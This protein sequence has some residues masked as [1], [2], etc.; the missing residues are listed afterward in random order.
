MGM[1]LK[2]ATTYRAAYLRSGIYVRGDAQC[3]HGCLSEDSFGKLGSG[4]RVWIRPAVCR[5]PHPQSYQSAH[6]FTLHLDEGAFFLVACATLVQY[7]SGCA[8]AAITYT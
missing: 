3:T 1:V 6:R 4:Y 2:I 8:G 5:Q 7:D